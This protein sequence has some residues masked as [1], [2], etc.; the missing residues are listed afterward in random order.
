MKG[1]RKYERVILERGPVAVSSRFCSC[2]SR[3][4]LS[5]SLEQA[6]ASLRVLIG[7]PLLLLLFAD[8]FLSIKWFLKAVE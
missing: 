7:D 6:K 5:R 8:F 3:T 2:I 4:R 1:T